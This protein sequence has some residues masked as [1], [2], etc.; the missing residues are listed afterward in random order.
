[1]AP[2]PVA[3]VAEE[4]HVVGVQVAGGGI[5]PVRGV[6]PIV[7]GEGR[8]QSE[9][10]RAVDVQPGGASPGVKGETVAFIGTVQGIPAPV[11]FNPA[12]HLGKVS[13]NVVGI[14]AH[15]FR[16]VA[17]EGHFPPQAGPLRGQDA[18][19]GR[20]GGGAQKAVG[21][22]V[23]SVVP[24]VGNGAV[25]GA[26]LRS[27]LDLPAVPEQ[28]GPGGGIGG[29]SRG[30]Q[31]VVRLAGSC[32]HDLAVPVFR[33]QLGI[34][35]AQRAVSVDIEVA[36]HHVPFKENQ[37]QHPFRRGDVGFNIEGGPVAVSLN[38][39]RGSVFRG[40]EGSI[41]LR[42]QGINHERDGGT[43]HELACSVKEKRGIMGGSGGGHGER[44]RPG[45]INRQGME[46]N[47]IG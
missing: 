18:G 28:D 36:A 13:L 27:V 41:G 38:G 7:G 26:Q 4:A 22:R 3:V 10:L 8:A 42:Q 29:I 37:F 44:K 21:P 17:D 20:S 16:A 43:V 5:S 6:I 25:Q 24:G 2:F 39:Q 11:G 15:G 33:M 1:M 32:Q 45:G 47:G 40:N 34:I 12:V 35:G 23:I 30:E 9:I 31:G 46:Q 19:N 14:E